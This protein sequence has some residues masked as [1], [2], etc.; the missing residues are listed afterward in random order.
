MKEYRFGD[1]WP[2]VYILED[3]KEAYVGESVSVFNR[4]NQHLINTNRSKLNNMFVIADDEY[5]K[6]ATLDI[7]SMLIKF[8]AGDGQYLLQNANHGILDANYYDR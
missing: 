8:M 2:V 7:E 5:N 1:N 3:G 4:A 6:S